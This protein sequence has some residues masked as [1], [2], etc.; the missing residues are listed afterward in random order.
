MGH[1]ESLLFVDWYPCS[2]SKLL[3]LQRMSLM[4]SHYI[5]RFLKTEPY[6]VIIHRE[7]GTTL[8]LEGN[9]WSWSCSP[10]GRR[11]LWVVLLG[12][13]ILWWQ[14]RRATACALALVSS[15][16]L[17]RVLKPLW[18]SDG[19]TQFLMRRCHLGMSY[20]PTKSKWYNA[21]WGRLPQ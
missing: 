5:L 7:T 11:S 17:K 15:N 3:P 21:E 10:F 13:V 20:W 12:H 14:P 1:W 2:T 19:A 6:T 8:D 16:H 9:S 18:Y 4:Y